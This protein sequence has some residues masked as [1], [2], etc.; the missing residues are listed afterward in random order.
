MVE[1]PH[2]RHEMEI[3]SILRV[4]IH[5]RHLGLSVFAHHR[6]SPVVGLVFNTMCIY[7]NKKRHPINS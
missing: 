7:A 5:C 6:I 3:L 2:V 4:G 1:G